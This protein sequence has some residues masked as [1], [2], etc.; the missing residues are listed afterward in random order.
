MHRLAIGVATATIALAACS[1]GGSQADP[2]APTTTNAG[3]TTTTTVAAPTTTQ[4][5][6][7]DLAAKTATADIKITYQAALGPAATLAQDGEGKSAFLS[8][9]KLLLSDGAKVISCDGTTPRATCTD[10]GPTSSDDALTQLIAGYA[11]L[12][13]IKQTN[14]GV[15]STQTI[16]GRTSSCVTFK[17]SDYA[18]GTGGALPDSSKLTAAATVTICVDDDSGFALKIALSDR[19]QTV[20]EVLATQVGVPTASDFVPPS[21]PVPAATSTTVAGG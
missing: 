20:N 19:G 10:L 1:G 11:G 18:A 6:I 5:A 16:A 9:G 15:A 3:A 13:T 21:T 17:A 8:G 7:A 14:L 2:P 12:S 4:D